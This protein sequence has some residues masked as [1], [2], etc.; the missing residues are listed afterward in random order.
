M[1]LSTRK[2]QAYILNGGKVIQGMDPEIKGA[3]SD[4]FR[5]F[6]TFRDFSMRRKLIFFSL[7]LVNFTAEKGTVWKILKA[8]F[9]QGAEV[10]RAGPVSILFVCLLLQLKN[11]QKW[12]F[13]EH[14][15]H[16]V[17]YLFFLT[18]WTRLPYFVPIGPYSPTLYIVA[19]RIVGCHSSSV[20][21]SVLYSQLV[22]WHPFQQNQQ[23]EKIHCE[24]L[25]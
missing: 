1:Q 20:Y 18:D 12:S 21:G 15:A 7:S 10:A 11:C 24:S 5:F 13:K 3:R 14:N 17:T 25:T 2:W 22:S 9:A 19:M 6:Q 8:G 16:N 23:V 4:C